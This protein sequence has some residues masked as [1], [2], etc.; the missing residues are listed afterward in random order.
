MVIQQRKLSSDQ[1]QVGW[2]ICKCTHASV[3]LYS[4][5]RYE[6]RREKTNGNKISALRL[7]TCDKHPINV[8]FRSGGIVGCRTTS[9]RTFVC[10]LRDLNLNMFFF[11]LAVSAHERECESVWFVKMKWKIFD[12]MEE[13]RLVVASPPTP[14]WT[15]SHVWID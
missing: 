7:L 6:M 12:F 5:R 11:S 15:T 2:H 9:R 14:P 3:D 1:T 10:A 13:T 8:S 4:K